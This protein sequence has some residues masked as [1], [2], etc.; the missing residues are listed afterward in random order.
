MG[1]LLSKLAWF[2]AKENEVGMEGIKVSNRYLACDFKCE[3]ISVNRY[4]YTIKGILNCTDVS[5]SRYSSFI[6]EN[7]YDVIAFFIEDSSS[8]DSVLVV[9]E[10]LGITGNDEKILKVEVKTLSLTLND[11]ALL[12]SNECDKYLQRLG[13]VS[14]SSSYCCDVYQDYIEIYPEVF[15]RDMDDTK[16]TVEILRQGTDLSPLKEMGST[17]ERLANM[18]NISMLE[19]MID[20]LGEFELSISLGD[21]E[22]KLAPIMYFLIK[23]K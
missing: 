14:K 20:W 23:K 16:V 12:F 7:L 21:I 4:F 15:H 22:G 5:S 13:I 6:K 17:C 19:C 11:M 18:L 1:E 9:E 2:V 8:P 3:S 10:T